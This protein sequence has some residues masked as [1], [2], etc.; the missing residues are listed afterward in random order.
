MRDLEDLNT[1]RHWFAAVYA[2]NTDTQAI[3]DS[4]LKGKP[5][6]PLALLQNVFLGEDLIDDH[7]WSSWA[8]QFR[9]IAPGSKIEFLATVKP[10]SKK[11]GWEYGL[12]EIAWIQPV[13]KREPI[14]KR[15]E[16]KTQQDATYLLSLFNYAYAKISSSRFK[17]KIRLSED[18]LTEQ[19]EAAYCPDIEDRFQRWDEQIPSLIKSL[20]LEGWADSRPVSLDFF[21]ERSE[22][23]SDLR[24][25]G[26]LRDKE[27]MQCCQIAAW[28]N[29]ASLWQ[30][31]GE[32]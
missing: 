27:V 16:P 5:P 8:Q 18:E 21:E 22:A 30:A 23:I 31:F 6:E 3:A 20:A 13:G 25:I 9:A 17:Q 7:I 12:E 15:S 2:G 29:G 26:R 11:H 32:N 4:L 14:I 10:Y 28:M 24:A 1:Q 19:F